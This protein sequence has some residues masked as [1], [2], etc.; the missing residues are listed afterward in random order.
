MALGLY[1]AALAVAILAEAVFAR[2]I[3]W[4][5]AVAAVLVTCGN[6]LSILFDAAWFAVLAGFAVF[7]IIVVSSGSVH[8]APGGGA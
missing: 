4:A 1:L 2:W 7:Q 3:G 6:L 8:V 5:S